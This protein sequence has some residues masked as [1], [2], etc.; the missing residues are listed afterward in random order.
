MNIFIAS[1]NLGNDIELRYTPAGKAIGSFSIPV[2]QGYGEHQKTSW[3]DCK[4]FGE[5]AE[6]LKEYLVKGKE[7]TV[8]GSFVFEQWEKDGIKH[9][10]PVIIVNELDM[11]GGK[12]EAKPAKSTK[13]EPAA[14]ANFD[15]FDDDIPF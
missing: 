1:G 15:N 6:K 12:S 4:L 9:G 3:V 14:P 5:R 8:Q 11:H 2:K 10:K 7:V 13:Q